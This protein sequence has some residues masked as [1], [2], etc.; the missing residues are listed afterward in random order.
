MPPRPC[1]WSFPPRTAWASGTEKAYRLATR[2][3]KSKAFFI[4]KLDVEHADFYKTF[5]GIKE[6][7]GNSVCP[8]IIPHM[9]WRCGRL[10]H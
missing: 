8:V 2:M 1:C 4:N 9:G 3:N 5:E 10:L 6:V 7:F